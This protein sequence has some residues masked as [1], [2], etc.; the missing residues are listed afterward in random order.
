[1]TRLTHELPPASPRTD[2]ARRSRWSRSAL[3]VVGRRG[4]WTAS[5]SRA[6]TLY[7]A[8]GPVAGHRRRSCSSLLGRVLRALVAARARPLG[9]DADDA[10]DAPLRRR[11]ALRA[12]R[13]RCSSSTRSASSAAACRSGSPPRCSSSRYVFAFDAD[14]ARATPAAARGDAL[15]RSRRRRDRA[16]RDAACSSSVFLVR[17][18]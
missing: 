2:R 17:L 1:M 6:R 5:S 13:P 12:R 9:W 16:R 8:P 10:D 3:A 11:R 7:T 15:A 4:G 14:A 18:P